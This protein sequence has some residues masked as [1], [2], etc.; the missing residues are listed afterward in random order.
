[1]SDVRP[2]LPVQPAVTGRPGDRPA[3]VTL[4]ALVTTA[5]PKQWVKNVLVFAA[6]GAAGVLTHGHALA[7]AIGAFAIFCAV[8]SGTY[9]LNDSLDAEADRHHP[10]KQYRP[11]ASGAI[12]RPL[13][14][15]VGASLLALGSA[16]PPSWAGV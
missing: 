12:P 10:A 11:I 6:P 1:M 13:G 16:H 9:F 15:A 2:P 5:R 3:M 4:A 14:V 7:G 8:A